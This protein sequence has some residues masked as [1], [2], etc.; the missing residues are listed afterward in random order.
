MID[1]TPRLPPAAQILG[2]AGLLPPLL[3][4]AAALLVPAWRDAA[5]GLGFG[6]AALIFSFLG[7]V[8]WG[9]AVAARGAPGWLWA[10]AVLPSLLAW[11][12]GLLGGDLAAALLGGLILLSPL[13]DRAAGR[14]LGAPAG[15]LA[16]RLRLSLGLGGLTLLLGLV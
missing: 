5:Q 11:A 4:L 8:W 9:G 3:C 6:Y 12:L 1:D 13:V 10:A 14:A 16:L 15:W 2:H 7:G